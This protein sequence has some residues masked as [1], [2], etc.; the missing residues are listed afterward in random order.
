MLHDYV[1]RAGDKRMTADE[2]RL[3]L[4]SFLD[5]CTVD[6]IKLYNKR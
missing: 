6:V 5:N 2:M 1:H 4:Q 3:I